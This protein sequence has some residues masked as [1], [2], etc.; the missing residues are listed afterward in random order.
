MHGVKHN[1]SDSARLKT[2]IEH[3]KFGM[4]HQSQANLLQSQALLGVYVDLF[5]I[6][7]CTPKCGGICPSPYRNTMHFENMN[8]PVHAANCAL[9]VLQPRAV[10]I[11]TILGFLKLSL[12]HISYQAA[13]TSMTQ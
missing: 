5:N 6:E 9:A 1:E 7:W 10:S 3:S 4:C 11:R 13:K 12:D 8:R 2:A